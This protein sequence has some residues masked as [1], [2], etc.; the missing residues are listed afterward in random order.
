[1]TKLLLN[2]LT[3]GPA[4]QQL[5]SFDH[6]DM[7]TGSL[8]CAH[9]THLHKQLSQSDAKRWLLAAQKSD[10]FAAGLCAALLAGKQVILPANTQRGTLSELN[11]EFDAIIADKPLCEVREFIVLKKELSLPAATWPQAKSLGELILFT[12]GSSGQ[13]K[14]ITKTLAQLDAE[15]SILEHTFA[16]HL[17][18]CS[19]VSTV[20]HQHIY[21]LLFK[22]LWPLAA[23][24]AFLSEQ[25]DFPETLSYY[26]AIMPNLCL[27]SSPAQLTRL[28][29]ALDN[30]PQ[31]RIPSLIFSSGGP[32]NFE[33]AQAVKQC[34]KQLPIE[35]FGSTETGGIAYRRQHQPLQTWQ[36]FEQ[37]NIDADPQDGALIL[38]SV[39]LDNPDAWV[40]CDD[41]IEL[42][43]NGQFRLLHRLDRIVKIEE[44]RLSLA[45]LEHLLQ[46]HPF[47]SDA[48][49]TVLEQPRTML[50]AAVCLNELGRQ[51]LK[52]EG[53]LAINT[54]LKNHL[55]SQFERITLPKRWRYPK[56]LPLNSQGKR[57]SADIAALF[58]HD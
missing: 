39:Y 53:K 30:Q 43:E 4:A 33:S 29:D 44:K 55:L 48:A 46:T 19:V 28:P 40:K 47:V 32:L 2:W 17:P 25:I 3:D 5:I 24:R 42:V 14:A 36:P 51:T 13:P 31:Q 56:T 21:G 26:L 7:M 50:G 37:V 38:Q 54:A 9:V 11:H 15:V 20:S 49:V 34:F 8:F 10:L 6:H 22:I 57:T 27:I 1:M 12:S 41:K 35:V 58:I 52:D 23:S 18:H 45:Q 16:Q